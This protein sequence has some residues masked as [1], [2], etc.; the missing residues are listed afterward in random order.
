[1]K[2]KILLIALISMLALSACSSASR[3]SLETPAEAPAA[4]PEYGA[5]VTEEGWSKDESGAVYEAA[6]QQAQVERV[7]LKSAEIT[8]SVAKPN[9]L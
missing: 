9:D 3:N 6:G 7:V 4:M 8:I 2:K 1:M 5:P